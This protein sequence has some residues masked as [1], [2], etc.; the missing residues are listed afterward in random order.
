MDVMLIAMLHRA[1]TTIKVVRGVIV[2]AMQ[3]LGIVLI[4][5]FI[6]IIIYCYYYLL[7][8]TLY[9]IVLKND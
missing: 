9:V 8:L 3:R 4:I 6:V 5:S 1:A 7:F 2:T